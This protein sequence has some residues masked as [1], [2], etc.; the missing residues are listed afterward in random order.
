MSDDDCI[1]QTVH[2]DNNSQTEFYYIGWN[3]TR[4]CYI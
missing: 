3:Q 1:K 2:P 4:Y